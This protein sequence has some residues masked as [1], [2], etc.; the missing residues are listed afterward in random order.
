MKTTLMAAAALLCLGAGAAYANEVE[1]G[2]VVP[3]TFFSEL[4]GE[5]ATP[6]GAPPNDV[7]P[8]AYYST[9]PQSTATSTTPQSAPSMH[10]NG[11]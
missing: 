7:S 9:T 10:A 4:P 3:N 5:I 1:D 2:G 6:P 11:S 8:N